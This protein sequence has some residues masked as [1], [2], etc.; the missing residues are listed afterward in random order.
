VKILVT[1]GPTREYF[2]SVRF[3]SNPSSGKMGY[4]IAAAA[5]A[6]GHQVVL[7]SGPVQLD[8]PAGVQTI[9]V[10]SSAEMAEQCKAAWPSC[11]VAFMTAAVCDYRP[12][13][14]LIKKLK[15]SNKPRHVTLLPTEDIA[16]SL[17]AAKRPGQI[18]VTFAMED[19][20]AHRHAEQKSRC[21]S[22]AKDGSDGVGPTKPP[23]RIG[24]SGLPSASPG[25]P[26]STTQSKDGRDSSP[27]SEPSRERPASRDFSRSGYLRPAPSLAASSPRR[28]MN[29]HSDL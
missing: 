15:K 13:K 10:V 8:P 26:S 1:A 7:I 5:A 3:I 28:C 6:R 25:G 18:L 16:G 11:D 2:D 20:D 4:A 23:W 21:S 19:H 14:T 9:R 27:R 24:W 12:A 29:T 22:P 17:G